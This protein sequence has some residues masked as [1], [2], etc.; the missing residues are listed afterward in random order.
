MIRTDIGQ[1][2]EKF[3]FT[4]DVDGLFIEH[5]KGLSV[6]EHDEVV[7]ELFSIQRKVIVEDS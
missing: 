4:A 2:F 5:R 6:E 7:D 1:G 3:V